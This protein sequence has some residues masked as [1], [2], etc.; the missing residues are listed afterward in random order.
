LTCEHGT[1]RGLLPGSVLEL[2]EAACEV[3][4]VEGAVLE[5]GQVPVNRGDGSGQ[6]VLGRRQFPAAGILVGCVR[7]PGSGD[8]VGDEVVLVAVE[9]GQRAGN[10][11]L[12]GVGVD[13]LATAGG[14]VVSGAPGM[15]STGTSWSCRGRGCRAWRC[16][17]R[18][19]A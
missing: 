9:V 6:L 11:L 14:G 3:F 1:P 7:G 2:G 8:G 13:P 15:S 16:R 19:S 10:R 12:D 4:G 5:R 17:T 18:G